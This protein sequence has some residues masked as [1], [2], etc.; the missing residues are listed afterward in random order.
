MKSIFTQISAFGPLINQKTR[1]WFFSTDIPFIAKAYSAEEN[2]V[3]PKKNDNHLIKTAASQ[4]RITKI[5]QSEAIKCPP[6][7]LSKNKCNIKVLF[8]FKFPNE[9]L[10]EITT[11]SLTKVLTTQHHFLP[12]EPHRTGVEI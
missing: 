6:Q 8:I 12:N 10:K 3:S 5:N 7:N 11:F 9:L 1:G 4:K 2:E